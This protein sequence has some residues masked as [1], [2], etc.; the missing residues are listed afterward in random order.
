M[1]KPYQSLCIDIYQMLRIGNKETIEDNKIMMKL[2]AFTL[3]KSHSEEGQ[4]GRIRIAKKSLWG[5]V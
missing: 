4:N 3:R 5:K 1:K 2:L